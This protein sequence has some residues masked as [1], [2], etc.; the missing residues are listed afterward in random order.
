MSDTQS[1]KR[2]SAEQ[3]MLF[4]SSLEGQRLGN[5]RAPSL[6]LQLLLLLLSTSMSLR[7]AG[8]TTFDIITN[9]NTDNPTEASVFETTTLAPTQIPTS[10]STA[11]STFYPTS[12]APTQ[13]P[14]SSSSTRAGEVIYSSLSDTT[15]TGVVAVAWCSIVLS[16]FGS[17]SIVWIILKNGKLGQLYHRLMLGMSVMDLIMTSATAA[18]PYVNRD[19]VGFLFARGNERTC[20]AAGF[21]LQAWLGST[22]Y[23]AWLS[24]YFLLMVCYGYKEQQIVARME[25][26]CHILAILL[27]LT[28]GVVGLATDSFNTVPLLGICDFSPWPASCLND[29]GVECERGEH[30]ETFN[31]AHISTMVTFVLI[32]ISCTVR[33]YWVVRRQTLHSQGHATSSS[34]HLGDNQQHNDPARIR[35]IQAVRNQA[36]CY[37]SAFLVSFLSAL[38]ALFEDPSLAWPLFLLYAFFPLQGVLNWGIYV[39]PRLLRWKDANPEKSWFWAYRQILG[40]KVAPTTRRTAHLTNTT[41]MRKRQSTS[42]FF[43]KSSRQSDASA[44]RSGFFARLAE[45]QHNPSAVQERST[46]VEQTGAIATA[47]QSIMQRETTEVW[48][49]EG[50]A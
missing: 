14:T 50:E 25:P 10:P 49:E 47:I 9:T 26:Y 3:G 44:E 32:G 41:S 38:F 48:K 4:P 34:F 5:R 42:T 11:A 40:G 1:T 17:M 20:E 46:T 23:N 6:G 28:F 37:T 2:T 16:L 31:L 19:D 12:F 8:A 36:I 45:E 30:A 18:M 33:V 21:F 29:E 24:V 43:C 22:I 7:G 39:R 27:P 15:Y 35:R 13:L